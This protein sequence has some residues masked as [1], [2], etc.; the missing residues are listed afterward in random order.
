VTSEDRGKRRWSDEEITAYEVARD[1]LNNLIGWCSA[2]LWREEHADHPDA[3]LVAFLRA[4]LARYERELRELRPHDREGVG[5][6]TEEYAPLVR[7]LYR[8]DT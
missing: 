5:R 7:E 6:V 4:Q 1:T 3:E 2:R 8:R